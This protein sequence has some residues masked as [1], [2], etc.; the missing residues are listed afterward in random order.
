MPTYKAHLVKVIEKDILVDASNP[1]EAF[2][3]VRELGLETVWRNN[4]TEQTEESYSF[5]SVSTL[6]AKTG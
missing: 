1:E 2:Q 3:Q 5:R 4:E 6:N